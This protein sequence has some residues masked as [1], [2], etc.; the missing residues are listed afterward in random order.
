MN[1]TGILKRVSIASTIVVAVGLADMPYGY[2]SL[3][4]ISLCAAAITAIWVCKSQVHE[5]FIWLLGIVAIIYNPLLP[6][7]FGQKEIWVVANI[8]TLLLFWITTL[9]IRKVSNPESTYSKEVALNPELDKEAFRKFVENDMIFVEPDPNSLAAKLAGMTI[10][11]DCLVCK[12][13]FSFLSGAIPFFKNRHGN[14]YTLCQSCI[15][16]VNT[17]RVDCGMKPVDFSASAYVDQ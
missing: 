2:Y 17:W 13:R 14:H 6:I 12:T 15:K 16:L 1:G 11:S 4:K 8:A 9:R 3:L 10:K 5:A 7:R